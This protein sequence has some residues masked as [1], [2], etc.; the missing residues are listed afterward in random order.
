MGKEHNQK[1]PGS[2]DPL[3]HEMVPWSGNKEWVPWS[4]AIIFYH[5]I[6]ANEWFKRTYCSFDWW[7]IMIILFVPGLLF[8]F[9]F[10][11]FIFCD[12]LTSIIYLEILK[13]L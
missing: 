6:G 9:T 4:D 1:G 2:L 10:Y 7:I 3:C 12:S 5:G 13:L 8:Y 11:N